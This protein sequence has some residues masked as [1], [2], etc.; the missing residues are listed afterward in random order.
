MNKYNVMPIKISGL[1]TMKLEKL[2]LKSIFKTKIHNNIHTL[3]ML[4]SKL[5]SKLVFSF[6]NKKLFKY[7]KND[8]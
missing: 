3:L 8:P 2:I 4:F 1:F 6:F 5:L 7:V